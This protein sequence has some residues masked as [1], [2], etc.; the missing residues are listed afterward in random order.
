[1]DL[2]RRIASGKLGASY[3][4]DALH[5]LPPLLAVLHVAAFGQ[6]PRGR[7]DSAVLPFLSKNCNGCH[8]EKVSSGTLNLVQYKTPDSVAVNRDRWELVLKRLKA[9]E[10]PPPPLPAT[11]DPGRDRPPLESRRV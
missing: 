1:M 3:S 4:P 11:P 6:S 2:F 5:F 7:F 9:G 10:M 8:N